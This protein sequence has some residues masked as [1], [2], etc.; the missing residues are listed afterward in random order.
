MRHSTASPLRAVLVVGLLLLGLPSPGAAKEQETKAAILYDGSTSGSTLLAPPKALLSGTLL[1]QSATTTSWFLYPNACAER[2]LNTWS[3]RTSPVADSLNSYSAGTTGPYTAQDQSLKETLWHVFDTGVPASQRPAPLEGTRSLWCGKYDPKAV[4]TVGYPNVTY[5][6][7]YVDTGAHSGSYTLT[8][9]FQGSTEPGYD[10]LYLIGGGGAAVDPIGNSRPVLDNVI[11][12]GSNGASELLVTWTGTIT[13]STPGA[14]SISTL[15]GPV[16]ILGAEGG[17]PA[18]VST[19]ITIAPGHRALYFVFTSEERMSSED[20]LW[21]NGNGAELDLLATSD[22]GSIYSN[23]AAVGGT[24]GFGGDVIVGTP[25]SPTVSARVP[26][27]IG[28][29]WHLA[30]GS[31]K[32]TTD[33]CSPAKGLGSDL[34]FEAGDFGTGMTDPGSFASI[35]TCT[36]PIPNG[37]SS[38]TASWREYRDLERGSGLV[39]VTEYRVFGA[40]GWSKWLNADT[41]MSLRVGGER[42]W[43][44]ASAELAEAARADSVQLRF[45]VQCVPLLSGDFTHCSS[46]LYG[47][48]YDDLG[49]MVRTGVPAPTFG[50]YPGGLPQSTFV[51]GT[52]TGVNCSA[53]PC[54]PGIRGSDL[55]GGIAIKDNVNSP[56][57]D[58][59][60]VNIRS[61]LRPRGMGINWKRGYDPTL[62]QGRT[63]FFTNGSYNAAFDTPRMIYRLFDPA[64]KSWSP[65][66][67]TE[68]DA[69]AVAVANS[70]TT[71]T[72]GEYRAVWPPRDKVDAAASL[73]GGFTINGVGAYASLAFLPRGTRLQY[74]FKAVDINGG[75]VYQ[76]G[77]ED[78]PNEVEDLPVLPGG[79]ARAPDILEFRVLP[80]AYAPGA[81]A[82]LLAGRTDTPVLN[83][84]GAYTIWSYGLDPVTQALRG[85]GVRADRYRL[86]Q[87]L[88]G[89]NGIGGHELT[90]LRAE[91][92]NTFFPSLLEYGIRDSLAKWYRILIVSSHTRDW[93]VAD[94][95]DAR[96]LSEWWDA[97]T[98]TDGGDRCLFASGD[99]FFNSLI[100]PPPG[101]PGSYGI[102]M[103]QTVFG[104]SAATG[105]WSGT[106]SS[107]YPTIDDRFAAPSAGPGLAAPGTYTY[108]IDGGCPGVNR[109]DALTKV[110][111]PD[112]QSAV[113][114]PSSEVA[115]IARMSERDG[116]TDADRNKSLGYAFSFQYIRQAGISTSASS[117]PHSGLENRL[118][119]LY[120]FLTSCRGARTGAPSDTGKCWPCPT[121]GTTVP[122]MQANWAVQAGFVTTTYGPL[123]PIQDNLAVTGLDE[124]PVTESVPRVNALGQ[125]RPNP[126]NPQTVIPYSLAAKGR[127]AIRI[128]NIGGRLVRT[129]LDERQ[130]AGPHE[131]RWNGA[132]ETGGHAASGVYF[133]RITYPDGSISA[134]KMMILR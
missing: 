61:S 5:Q 19:S 121:P 3:P 133:Y 41:G 73:P 127:V 113:S 79:S 9:L 17:A 11:E 90:G 130:E 103:A 53:P 128:F 30:V 49:L 110:A 13:P 101:Y 44:A 62:N 77:S 76:F 86:L 107:L 16:S 104:V 57:G 88:G 115:A 28:T 92:R 6:I 132:T 118:R 36:F 123:Y 98:G 70:D 26:T 2:A 63:I 112:A 100:H 129:L 85:L 39:A 50:L 105:S 124:L 91:R 35:V 7:L 29:L 117:Y 99:D 102:G 24:D 38:V 116:V 47:L 32:P 111:A 74:Y 15:G 8:L 27:A 72:D 78:A 56:L 48:F 66:D 71:V 82:T 12:N 134:K 37:T 33:F 40:D 59:L 51:D 60:V 109:F 84:D 31:S 122:L 81:V 131:V 54:W 58:S 114:Y 67:S 106:G 89:G 65:F 87:V 93:T 68:L 64:T 20:G 4:Q 18:T 94:E 75:I 125:N 96:L 10:F 80:G 52:M 119:V 83:V 55:S 25:G 34:F 45:T 46:A 126:F 23:Q 22:N 97:S 21:P 1:K 43:S 120:K 14:A 69:N 108:P 42:G 95:Q